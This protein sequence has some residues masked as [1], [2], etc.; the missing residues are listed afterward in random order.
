MHYD[1]IAEI[2]VYNLL[3]IH[4]SITWRLIGS[5]IQFKGMSLIKSIN[6][7]LIDSELLDIIS[8]DN[9]SWKDNGRSITIDEIIEE[10]EN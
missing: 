1:N 6:E 4:G 5:E 9:K 10:A 2:P 3:K 7:L 8:L